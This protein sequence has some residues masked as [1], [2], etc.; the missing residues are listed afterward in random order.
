MKN[1]NVFD[2]GAKGDGVCL[3]TKAIQSA[4]DD[5][6]KNGGGRV[7][8]SSGSFLF[9]RIDLKD[10]VELHIERDAVLLGS[11]NVKDFPEIE[12]DFWRTE[13]APR[14]NKRCYIYAENA[15]DIAITGRGVIDCQGAA[16]V[17]PCTKEE[18][19]NRPHMSYKRKQFPLPEG[20]VADPSLVAMV[21]TNP[22]PLDPKITSLAPARVI[23][24]IGCENVLLEDITIRN[25]PAGWSTWITDCEDVHF[26]RLRIT[27]AL[28]FPNC[29]GLHINC[30]RNVTVSDCNIRTGDDCIVIRAYSAPLHKN[31]KCEGVTVTNCN[32]KSHTAGIRIGWIGDGEMRNFTFSN[33]TITES[34]TGILMRLPPNPHSARMADQGFEEPFIENISFSNITIDRNYM[35]PIRIEI[36]DHSPCKAIQNI[37]FSD[38][39]AFSARMPEIKGRSDI[40]LR[41]IYFNN[42]HFRQIRYED[43]GTRFSERMV[44]I[45]RPITPPV[46][47]CVDNLV[48]NGTTFDLL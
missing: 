47:T 29:D 39:H 30:C 2:Y 32:F 11:T 24:F 43:I 20:V 6:S 21:G 8:L 46:F 33:L 15:K 13:Y 17:I 48:L 41:N 31:T 3:D 35:A 16:F 26:H 23:L 40:H 12:T 9:G 7:T 34:I 4:I 37:Y 10:G 27:S 44:K 42:C 19:D 18:I 45:N 38:I 28:D 5:C 25:Q 22:H 36:E 1:C 14:F